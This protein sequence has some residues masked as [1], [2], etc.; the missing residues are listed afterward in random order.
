VA[1]DPLESARIE[2][3]LVQCGLAAVE[4]I[5]VADQQPHAV[6]D[7]EIEQH[8]VELAGFR[9]FVPLAEL[10][11]HEQQLLARVGILPGVEQAQVGEA[12]PGVAGHLVEQALLHVHHFVV[13]QRQHEVLGPGVHLAEGQLVVLVLAVDRFLLDVV[14]GVVH[15][16]HVPLHRETQA[17]ELDRTRN[18]RPGG[19]FLGDGQHPRKAAVDLN[20][21]FAQELDRLDVL[22]PAVL[23]RQPL[24]GLARVVE[25]EH[26]G[27]RVDAD[28]VDVEFVDPVQGVG[29]EE[30]SY[31]VAAEVEDQRAPVLVFAAARV[32]VFVD[33]LAGEAR[34]GE[35][36]LGKMRR[37]PVEQDAEIMLMAGVDETAQRVGFAETR[38]RR[39]IA[40][41]LVAPRGIERVLGHRQK[42]DVCIAELEHVGDQGLDQLV[43]A[44][45]AA[46]GVASPRAGMQFVDAHRLV[47][48][49]EL[50]TCGDPGVVLPG[51]RRVVGNPAGGFRPRK[52]LP[53]V[54]VGLF[55]Q[56]AVAAEDF[57]LVGMPRGESG[58]EQ[59]PHAGRAA[60]AHRMAASVQS[61]KSPMTLT[62]CTAGAHTA[63][64]QPA[65]SSTTVARAPSTF[66]ASKWRPSPSR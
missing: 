3:E 38:G 40:G 57:V 62:R 13:R 8:P 26:R 58:N 64:W 43:P 36:V 61:L 51:I 11:A 21:E 7:R 39:V 41:N 19:G 17:A 9:P 46:V 37:H 34:Q 29:D 44:V 4:T 28:A 47:L 63:N 33:R 2:V 60:A 15:P 48:P 27:H 42:F 20:V 12:L 35:V 59:F 54:G 1:I 6:V 53:R 14:E 32:L 45:E 23:V 52:H 50:G 55:R 65:T 18:R 56:L 22:A 31:L 66:Q 49:V 16:A 25:V 5:E 10:A 24:A 30:V